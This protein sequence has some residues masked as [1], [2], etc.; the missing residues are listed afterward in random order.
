MRTAVSDLVGSVDVRALLASGN[1]GESTLTP[2]HQ[3]LLAEELALSQSGAARVATALTTSTVDLN[4]HQIEAASFAM[5]ALS[6]GGGILADEVGLGKTIE[7]GIVIGQLWAEGKA[8]ILILCPAP[9]RAQWQAELLEKFGLPGVCVDGDFAKSF[10]ANP[11]EQNGPVIA[12][13]QFGANRA[14]ELARIPWD[15]VVID[16]AH[17]L[18]NAWKPTNKTGKALRTALEGRPKLLLTATPL[19][20]DLMELFGLLGFLDESVLGPEHA[21]RARYLGCQEESAHQALAELK[22]RIEPVVHRTLRRQVREYVKFT[23]RRSMVEDFS[24]SAEEQDLYDKV[25]EYLRRAE[26]LAIEPGRRTLLTLVYRKLLASSTYAIAP[27]LRRLADSLE[28]RIKA[29][30]A[31]KA[32]ELTLT[33]SEVEELREFDEELEEIELGPSEDGRPRRAPVTV[34]ALEGE[35]HELKHY[36]RL[37]ES[38]KLNAKGEALCRALDRAFTVAATY[39]WPQ[40]AVVFTESKRTQEYLFQLLSS[41]GYRGQ[42]SKLSGDGSGPEERRLLVEEFRERTQILL[43]TEAG[44]EGLNLQF[45]NLVVNYDLPWNPQRIEQRIGRCHRYGQTR[46]VL[47][48]NFVNR[49]NAADA[50]LYELL[51]KKLTLFDGVFGASDEVLGALE[52]GIDFEKRVL[53]I[54][55]GCRT[56][57]EI[58]KAFEALRADLE[59]KIGARMA[60][61]RELL[62]ENFEDDV[63]NRLRLTGTTAQAA[64]ERRKRGSR[65][66]AKAVLGKEEASRAQ[67][68]AAIRELRSKP[69]PAISYVSLNASELPSRLSSLSGSEGWWFVYRFEVA[70][71]RPPERLVH[72]VLVRDGSTYRALPLSD[73]ELVARLTGK[74]ALGRCPAVLPVSA[75]QEAALANARDEVAGQVHEAVAV[76]ADKAREKAMRYAEDCLM[77]PREAVEKARRKWEEARAALMAEEDPALKVRARAALDRADREY[78]KRMSALRLEEDRRYGD[79]DRTLTMLAV[80]AKVNVNRTLI[81]TAYF[82]LE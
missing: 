57:A 33:R 1:T 72:I 65:A 78:R 7:A 6:R 62:L 3:R 75:A 71:A 56:E 10:R 66:L 39:R 36:A 22:G 55:Q 11:F 23:A 67:T 26:L 18:R 54:Y 27:T 45:C 58:T 77:A 81:A 17:R 30:R 41:R 53:D 13:I 16:E 46:D 8:R 35:L 48:L 29:A 20:N 68:E 59:G 52:S 63:R 50:R 69:A 70:G 5:E 64:I 21:F 49:S 28:E 32:F 9:L 80:R 14:A 31:G 42:I 25:S 4:P 19:Q 2:F 51:E 40:K 12:S 74:A 38:I 76:E 60:Q 79:L 24:Y 61:A 82:W 37:A 34:E 47:V 43:S 44:A 15:L 73:G